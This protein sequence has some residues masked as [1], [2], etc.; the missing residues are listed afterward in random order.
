M[1]LSRP[2]I[3]S[4]QHLNESYHRKD[5]PSD[6]FFTDASNEAAP[7]TSQ[8]PEIHRDKQGHSRS[9]SLPAGLTELMVSRGSCHAEFQPG[10]LPC[11]LKRLKLKGHFNQTLGGGI[12]PIYLTDLDL[13]FY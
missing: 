3:H 10:D 4:C 12:L 13:G 7:D 11:S 1:S 8:N 9:R 5:E 2:F 6:R